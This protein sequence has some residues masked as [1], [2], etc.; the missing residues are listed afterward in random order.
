MS[1]LAYSFKIGFSLSY[2]WKKKQ[3]LFRRCYEEKIFINFRICKR[4]LFWSHTQSD[5]Y[6][7]KNFITL[8]PKFSAQSFVDVSRKVALHI[9]IKKLQQPATNEIAR[10]PSAELID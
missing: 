10:L 9:Y 3:L 8:Y 7:F 2:N 6:P 5:K 4:K 1:L